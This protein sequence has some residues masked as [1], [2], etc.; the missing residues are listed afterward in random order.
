MSL[1]TPTGR[2]HWPR[3]A[4]PS[5]MS[6]RYEMTLSFDKN[7]DLS[8]LKEA[9]EAEIKAKWKKRPADLTLPFKDGNEDDPHQAGRTVIS[10]KSKDQPQI[11]GPDLKPIE[12]SDIEG[13]YPGCLARASVSVFAYEKNGNNGVSI[14]MNN[15]QKVADG[16]R[17]GGRM[18]AE[19]EFDAIEEEAESLL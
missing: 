9:V 13:L 11:V 4:E 14:W 5:R 16:P 1:C 8:S 2:V 18:P 19:E 7:T 6:D 10:L 3:V 17:I 12:P 15:I